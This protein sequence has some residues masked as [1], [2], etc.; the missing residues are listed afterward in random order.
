MNG[1]VSSTGVLKNV[2]QLVLCMPI[3]GHELEK[4]L[5]LHT[6]GSHALVEFQSF[7]ERSPYPEST[8]FLLDYLAG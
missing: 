2:T 3:S 1:V 5:K 8:G 4:D 6:E 7:G